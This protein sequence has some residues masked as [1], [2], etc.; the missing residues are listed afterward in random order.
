MQAEQ[1]ILFTCDRPGAG[2][3]ETFHLSKHYFEISTQKHTLL[4]LRPLTRE[5]ARKEVE[6]WKKAI[7]VL[8]HEV[9]NSLAPITSL[10]HSTRL[11]LASPTARPERLTA[12]LD[13][14]E[15]RARHLRTFLE[16]YSTFARLPLPAR[17][18]VP[19]RELLA[20]VEGLY[21][22]RVEGALP[23]API[24]G[25]PA[26]LQ[27][28]LINLLKNAA[29]SGSAGDEVTLSVQAGEG[30]DLVV[31][32][33]GKGMSAEVM[34]NALVPFYSTKK[35]GSGLGLP[36]CREIV[37]AHGGRLSLHPREGGGLVVRCWLPGPP[38]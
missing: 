9:N 6:T 2:E 23:A 18:P 5:L 7:R 12:A 16:G 17:R 32:D 1:G 11:L 26:Q 30:V 8:S 37:E 28:V 13:T 14:I 24:Y 25:D 38:G 33:R 21:P 20:G 4:L 3:A 19:W 15:E 35:G 34:R 10:L 31:Q 29:E 36:L 27:Q 22:Y